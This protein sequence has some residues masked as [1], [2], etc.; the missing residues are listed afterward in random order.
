MASTKGHLADARP[1]FLVL[2][3]LE[4][5]SLHGYDLYR[6]FESSL[7]KNW[8]ISQ[9]QMYLI[10]KRLEAQGDISAS[11]GTGERHQE[12]H[13][14]SLTELGQRRF[15]EWLIA[16]TDCGTRIIRFE[17]IS[18]LYFARHSRPELLPRIVGEQRA[19]IE[20]QIANH[21]ALLA[22]PS[23]SES[24]AELGLALRIGQLEAIA[25]W[26]DERVSPLLLDK[27]NE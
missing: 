13:L 19:E 23:P 5:G 12:K 2:G 16:P 22:A 18:R 14:F 25:R 7:G 3:F 21:K 9:S 15:D 8:K 6:R 24:F 10:L 27:E 20:G 4:G 11:V 17:F 1:E 26:L